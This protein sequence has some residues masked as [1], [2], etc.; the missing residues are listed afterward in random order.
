MGA[1]A[2][3]AGSSAPPGWECS[4]CQLQFEASHCAIAQRPQKLLRRDLR[5]P[6]YLAGPVCQPRTPACGI[7]RS[8][9]GLCARQRGRG[10]LLIRRHLAPAHSPNLRGIPHHD[11]GPR[12]NRCGAMG[13]LL[14][15]RALGERDF[16]PTRG[17]PVSQLRPAHT[18][19]ARQATLASW[20]HQFAICRV[21][22]HT[23][24]HSAP[25]A[26]GVWTSMADTPRPGTM[27][28]PASPELEH[29]LQ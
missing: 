8:P 1:R 26:P 5:E 21:A 15:R 3:R 20:R 19:L 6:A 25:R 16:A 10:P 14:V 18:S 12:T 22:T 24:A 11:G 13:A 27:V 4:C 29:R 7:A 28:A 9:C 23:S 2:G 17:P